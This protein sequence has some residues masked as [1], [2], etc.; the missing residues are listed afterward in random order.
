MFPRHRL[1]RRT[2]RNRPRLPAFGIAAA[3][4]VGALIL[5]AAPL[6]AG[7]MAE[8]EAI[9]GAPA[10][11]PERWS[12]LDGKVFEGEFGFAGEDATIG[13]DSWTFDEGMFVS[14][15]CVECGFPESPYWV[16]FEKD[17]TAFTART[18][19]PVS[20]AIITWR[21][22]VEDGRIEGTYTW[23][24]ERWYWTVEKEFWFR[25]ELNT[26]ASGSTAA[27]K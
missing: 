19:C 8:M 1:S 7:D 17:G 25:G 27:L 9:G 21:G 22:T 24:K 13:Q 16:S 18:Q 4:A 2:F 3:M 11:T 10:D 12:V 15:K 6:S 20:D 14:E 5:S 23:T 26:P